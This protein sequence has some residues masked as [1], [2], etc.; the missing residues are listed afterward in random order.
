MSTRDALLDW[1]VQALRAHG[2]ASNVLGVARH[3]WAHHESEPRDS[4]DMFYTCSTPGST[5]SAGRPSGCATR[6]GSGPSR[7]VSRCPGSSRNVRRHPPPTRAHV[8]RDRTRTRGGLT[9]ARPAPA[10]RNLSRGSRGSRQRR[11]VGDEQAGAHASELL[12]HQGSGQAAYRI[13]RCGD[14]PRVPSAGA[15]RRD[16]ARARRMAPSRSLSVGRR[17]TTR[18]LPNDAL[19]LSDM[20]GRFVPALDRVSPRRHRSLIDRR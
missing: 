2:G 4:G 18:L 11:A 9:R 3:I 14:A 1:V 17:R 8:E 7:T 12:G 16:I 19:P 10:A 20:H 15:R 5:T 6:D 13:R